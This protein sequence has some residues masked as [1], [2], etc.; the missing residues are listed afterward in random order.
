[1]AYK[2]GISPMSGTYGFLR[3]G[4][5]ELCVAVGDVGGY[6]GGIVCIRYHLLDSFNL[7]EVSV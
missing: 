3:R 1:M 2:H 7:L 5:L 4:D 6:K